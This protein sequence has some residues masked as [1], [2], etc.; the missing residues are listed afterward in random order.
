VR[1]SNGSGESN[2]D[3]LIAMLM[4]MAH[5]PPRHPRDDEFDDGEMLGQWDGDDDEEDY[6]DEGPG[7]DDEDIMMAMLMGMGTGPLV[8]T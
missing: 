2:E 1:G 6:E 8:Q 7:E 4:R 5:N 3:A